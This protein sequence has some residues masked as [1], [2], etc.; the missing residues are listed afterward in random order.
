MHIQGESHALTACG[1]PHAHAREAHGHCASAT[2]N[3]LSDDWQGSRLLT[4]VWPISVMSEHLQDHEEAGV[5]WMK[6]NSTQSV[7]IEGHGMSS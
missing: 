1:Q 3:V 7:T 4:Y 5:H 2:A 6:G